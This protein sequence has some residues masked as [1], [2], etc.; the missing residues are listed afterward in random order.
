MSAFSPEWLALREPADHRARSPALLAALHSHL[1]ARSSLSIVDLGC[2]TGS[3]LRAVAPFL[4][5][6]QHWRLVDHDPALLDAARDRIAR[7]ADRAR[8]VGRDL[9]VTSGGRRLT[10]TFAEVDLARDP[11]AALGPRPDLVTAAA[12][13]DLTSAAWIQRLAGLVAERGA[14]FYAALTYNGA[15]SWLPHH[16]DDAGVLSAFHAHQ[17][18]DKGFGPAAGPG[19]AARLAA[20]LEEVGYDVRTA[21]SP[22]VLAEDESDLVRALAQGIVAAARETGRVPD[23]ALAAWN[24]ARSRGASCRIGH[25]DVLAFPR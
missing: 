20:S 8:S 21:E 11:A 10:V 5:E 18:R 17:A 25:T 23:A 6:E 2:G 19:A 16:Q 12:L 14:A 22:W 24:E 4:P 7:W 1:R 13:F 9:A 3:N 15:E